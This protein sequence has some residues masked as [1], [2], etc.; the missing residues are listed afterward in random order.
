LDQRLKLAE[1]YFI[2][3][4]KIPIA[5]LNG[6]LSLHCIFFLGCLIGQILIDEK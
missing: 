3:S 5:I 1:S 6:K 2:T 4:S